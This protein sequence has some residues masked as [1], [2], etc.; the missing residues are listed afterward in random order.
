MVLAFTPELSWTDLPLKPFMVPLFQEAVRAGRV[1]ASSQRDF[2]TGEVAW[3]G[4]SART[5]LLVP[6]TTG[7]PT[8]EIDA[9]GRTRQPIPA[10]GL[11]KVKQRDGRERWIAVRLDPVAASIERVDDA[12]IEAWRRGVGSWRW[13]GDSSDADAVAQ[14]LDSPWTLPL[15]CVAMLC[16]LAESILSRFGSPRA[17]ADGKAVTA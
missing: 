4:S 8:I 9:E 6:R 1:L 2:R 17:Q 16:L 10:P 3:L 7:Q 14:G 11:W 12:S 13:L 5:G 15:L